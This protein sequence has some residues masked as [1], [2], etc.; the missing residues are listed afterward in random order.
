MR[1]RGKFMPEMKRIEVSQIK[2]GTCFSE[3]VFFEDGQ[4]MFLSDNKRATQVHLDVIKN[5][6]V[7][8]LLT[9]GEEI[10][11]PRVKTEKKTENPDDLEELEEI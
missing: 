8:Y 4:N 2:I 5:W 1:N 6:N 7:P 10:P 11:E 9:E 3:P